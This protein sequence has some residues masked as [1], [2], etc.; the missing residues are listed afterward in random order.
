MVTKRKRTQ[1]LGIWES[2]SRGKSRLQGTQRCHS[3]KLVPGA[4]TIRLTTFPSMDATPLP[5]SS[6]LGCCR[7]AAECYFGDGGGWR[8]VVG[9]ADNAVLTPARGLEQDSLQ[10]LPVWVALTLSQHPLLASGPAW[11]GGCHWLVA[12]QRVRTEQ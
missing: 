2:Q 8:E 6:G 10:P 12:A 1:R 9:W 5:P 7:T 4:L 3:P 11:G